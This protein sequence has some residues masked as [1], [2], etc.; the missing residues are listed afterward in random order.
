MNTCHYLTAYVP[1]FQKPLT[2]LGLFLLFTLSGFAQSNLN[3]ELIGNWGEGPRIC[4]EQTD[5]HLFV[6]NGSYL[7]I[8]EFAEG[9]PALLS[10]TPTRGLIND[11]IVND[12]HL[13]LGIEGVGLAI[14][15]ID[16]LAAPEELGFLPIN[17]YS[18][19]LQPYGDY[20]YY[21]TNSTMGLHLV[22][23]SNPG[24]PVLI[25]SF[26]VENVRNMAIEGHY[27]YMANGWNGFNVYEI[28]DATQLTIIYS[29]PEVFTY[30]VDVLDELVCVVMNDTTVFMDFTNPDLPETLSKLPLNHISRC[31]LDKSKERVFLCGYSAY[32][33][34]LS[35]V[36]DPQIV[37][38]I[39]L[40]SYC[41]DLSLANDQLA[42]STVY[43]G[44]DLLTID[45]N[46]KLVESGHINTVGFTKSIAVY[47]DYAY[48]ANELNG[49][50]LLDI[51]NP[52]SPRFIENLHTAAN[53]VHL[54]IIDH[55]L[56]CASGGLLILDISDP[57]NPVETSYLSLMESPD[58]FEV[59][60]NLLFLA[61]GSIGIVIIDI[62]DPANP[63]IISELDTPGD[64]S[65]ID[66]VDDLLYL[67]DWRSGLRIID[68]SNVY[69]PAEIAKI[70]TS[71]FTP[72]KA[73]RVFDQYA[74]IGSTNFGVRI[75]DISD[76]MNPTIVQDL[77]TSRGYDF[78]LKNNLVYISAGY[79]GF[80]IYEASD[81]ANPELVGYYDTPGNVY[82]ACLAE[83]N[84]IYLADNETGLSIIR[85]DKCAPINVNATDQDI[86]C[87]G[88]CD[89]MIRIDEVQH[90][91]EPIQL[92][93]SN[94]HSGLA[95]SDLCPG[96]YS[97]TITDAN[98]CE[99]IDSFI[100]RQP[101][102]LTFE[103]ITVTPITEFTT[104]GSIEVFI[105]G[106]TPVYQYHWT[107][108]NGFTTNTQHIHQ[109]STG[110]YQ[111]TVTDANGCS[112]M[113]AEL[114][115]EDQTIGIEQVKQLNP[116][117][118]YPNPTGDYLMLEMAPGQTP[119]PSNE[120]IFMEWQTF[121]GQPIRTMAL[122]PGKMDISGIP[123]G[124]YLVKI[125]FRDEVFF[126]KLLITR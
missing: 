34:N 57:E 122:S 62:S 81:P 72:L 6:N 59:R 24:V 5:G 120:L 29:V 78:R 22:D 49:L 114:C 104:F 124:L 3:T 56:Y 25:H 41:E 77:N 98:H 125:R 63:T 110:C 99:W 16:N 50:T 15:G 55:Y 20:L 85:F 61:A 115:I 96:T 46:G 38:T 37:H 66:L 14:F 95:L 19:N 9:I 90:A 117:E 116:V 89:G 43:L 75:V 87:F 54:Q 80:Y 67:A 100:L 70:D 108:P 35:N 113:S 97:I 52:Q 30:D 101:D 93:W 106:G 53:T 28:M 42:I 21:G 92:S 74:W 31:Q 27:L 79:K 48:L 45:E 68:I 11:L 13:Y 60:G 36:Y 51:S 73:V 83:E 10:K 91:L 103:S 7:E 69:A 94:G 12:T 39:Y 26:N 84:Q 107:G 17:G 65:Y 47:E 40:S 118:I 18:V 112:L 33:I 88:Y 76:P 121:T 123:N 109:G 126:H 105:T 64:A 111:V 71:W 82:S 86:S 102:E 8:Y 2:A 23:V 32:H 58:H 119:I 4:N 44:L 1:Y